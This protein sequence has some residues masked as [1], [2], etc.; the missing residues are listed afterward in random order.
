MK[1]YI[2]LMGISVFV[3][4]TAIVQGQASSQGVAA[5]ATPSPAV[6]SSLAVQP[7]AD[8]SA[9]LSQF[10]QAKPRARFYQQGGRITRVYGTPMEHGTTSVEAAER[11]RMKHAAMLGA[12]AAELMP[13]SPI[14]RGGNTLP[15]MHDLQTG[16][17]RFT[18]LYYTQYRDGIPVFRSDVRMLVGNAADHPIVWV[19]STLHRLGDFRPDLAVAAAPQAAAAMESTG[20][21]NFTSPE[22]VIW[23][24]V[25]DKAVEPVLAVTFIGDNYGA[26]MA[27]KPER[28][29]FVADAATGAILYKE[30]LVIM[31]DVVGNV[32]GMATEGFTSDVCGAEAA[33]PLKHAQVSIF[34]TVAYADGNGDFTIANEGSSEV[35]VVSSMTGRYFYVLDATGPLSDLAHSVT[36]PGPVNFMHNQANNSEFI[37]AQVNAY[38]SANVVRDYVLAYSPAYPVIESQTDFRI[39]VNRTD[40]YCPGNAWY[41]HSGINFCTSSGLGYPNTAYSSVVYHEYGHHVVQCGGS[42]QDQYGEGMSD[43][44]ASLIADDHVLAYGFD[45]DCSRGLRDADNDFQYPCSGESHTC[46]N[47]MSGCMWSTRNELVATNPTQ[48]RQIL[49][50]LTI[51]SVPLHSGALITPQITIDF[52]TLDDN[53]GNLDNGTPHAKEICAGFGAHNMGCP[54]GVLNS[55]DFQYPSGRPAE[56]Y[57]G[58]E[59]VFQINVVAAGAN[60]VPGSG[61]MHY[62]IDG[63]PW[64]TV[65]M[66]QTASNQYQAVWP[67]QACRNQI[68][69]Y[70]SA[71]ADDSLVYSDPIVAPLITYTAAV[72]HVVSVIGADNFENTSDWTAGDVGDSATSGLWECA[73]PEGTIAQTSEDHTPMPGEKC[74]VTGAAAG[75]SPSSNSVHGG[76]T[77]LLSPTL[78]LAGATEATISYWRWYSNDQGASPNSNI[79]TVDISNNNGGT[80]TNAETVGPGGPGTSGGWIRHVI[81]VADFVSLTAQ[82]K[83][84]FVA[85]EFG[86]PSLVE[87]AIDDFEVAVYQCDTLAPTP[88][89]PSWVQQ[90]TPIG[91]TAITMEAA[92]GDPSGVEYYFSATGS[93]S[94]NRNWDASPTF[95]DGAA[96]LPPLQVNRNYSYKVKARDGAPPTP[97]ETA[98]SAIV[99]VATFIETPVGL[100]FGTVTDTSIQMT[101]LGTFTRLNQNLSG[102]YF[103]VTTTDGT[104]AGSGSGVNTWTQLS[105]SRTVTAA[106]LLPGTTYRVRV[107]ARNYYGVNETPWYPASGFVTQG[108]TG[109]APCIPCGD[110]DHNGTVDYDDYVLITAAMGHSASQSEYNRCADADGDGVVTLV[111]YQV[112]VQCY[113]QFVGDAFAPVPTADLMGDVNGDGVVDG[114]DIQGFVD[115]LLDPPGAGPRRRAVSDFDDDGSVGAG[116]VPGFVELLL[117]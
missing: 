38:V 84:R 99:Y 35:T 90:P 3:A 72:G 58:Q 59:T 98:Y 113:R 107:K 60:P 62:S 23:A 95:T 88:N 63:G 12:E 85:S 40:G 44:I 17:H 36:P 1:V 37:R 48:Y 64:T 61:Q 54:A 68:E 103:E 76:K 26:P 116:D 6:A 28:W 8:E 42:G 20:M 18:L 91:T 108:T 53:D 65:A 78:N 4:A 109:N 106:G 101:A 16:E 94:H 71:E 96:P 67:S 77:T 92:A 66:S 102:L 25:E 87:S 49:S 19:G 83:L 9:A 80:W 22:T 24:G 41:D 114:R 2:P 10:V 112:W 81:R 34:S 57:P 115:A 82:I 31:T 43:C 47:L 73:V 52:L 100:S 5:N 69:W 7:S 56:V 14:L 86:D 39:T 51:N 33:T 15:L 89:P 29:L 27:D 55:I 45:D 79:F 97:N 70:V 11:F 117:K 21:T 110:L 13:V 93:G 111:D 75:E 46:G 105:S 30:N 32:S 50:A 104:P 74:W